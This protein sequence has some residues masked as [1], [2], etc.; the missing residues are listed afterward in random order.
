MKH[1][2]E[3][4]SKILI[5]CDDCELYDYCREPKKIKELTDKK[6]KLLGKMGCTN[7]YEYATI[8]KLKKI[9]F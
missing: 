2:I 7:P 6:M 1:W 9:R 3:K 5:I 4:K 8:K